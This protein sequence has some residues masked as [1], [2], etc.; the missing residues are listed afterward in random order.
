[1]R[2]G[3]FTPEQA[4]AIVPGICDALQAAH[5]QGIWHR[6]IKPENILL[7][8]DGR[9]KIVDFGI[10]RIVGDPARDFTLTL[11]GAALGSA[12]YMA[13]EQH[14]RTHEVDHRAD[15]YSLGVVF[16]EM[17]TG[18]LPLGRF[19]NPSERAAVHARIDAI[20]LQTLEKERELRQQTATEVKTDIQRAA[21]DG[22]SAPA[23]N[24]VAPSRAESWFSRLPSLVRRSLLAW[25]GGLL[26]LGVGAVLEEERIT[27]A[28]FPLSIG[29][30]AAVLGLLGG[31]W[32]LFEMRRGWLPDTGRGLL[33]ATT[34]LPVL[35]AVA[36]GGTM[37]AVVSATEI[38]YLLGIPLAF[39]C[40]FAV[41]WP[42]R[43]FL[44]PGFQRSR[45][46]V[47][48]SCLL[49][50]G[51]FAG[52][53]FVQGK[54]PFVDATKQTAMLGINTVAGNE[55]V[56]VTSLP[57]FRK[58]AGPL[59]PGY[60]IRPAGLGRIHV[61][62]L[63]PGSA[64]NSRKE[65]M[66]SVVARF[67]QLTDP[68]KGPW[69]VYDHSFIPYYQAD[70]YLLDKF[71]TVVGLFCGLSSLSALLLAWCKPR[72]GLSVA[73][74]VSILGALATFT[75]GWASGQAEQRF[76]P[77]LG[78]LPHFTPEELPREVDFT[79]PEATARTIVLA[80][81]RGQMDILREAVTPELAA[82]LDKKKEWE[83]FLQPNA[84]VRQENLRSNFA[85]P[86]P[87]KAKRQSAGS[88]AYTLVDGKWKMEKPD[89]APVETR[90]RVRDVPRVSKTPEQPVDSPPKEDPV[91]TI[92][93]LNRLAN[94][95]NAE[96]FLARHYKTGMPILFLN[97]VP[98]AR[99]MAP[100]Y[101]EILRIGELPRKDDDEAEVVA[102]FKRPDGKEEYRK[103]ELRLQEN[104]WRLLSDGLPE[105]R[106]WSLVEFKPPQGNAAAIL[107]NHLGKDPFH[108]IAGTDRF[109][110]G[111]KGFEADSARDD[112]EQRHL[113][114]D[115]SLKQ[116]GLNQYLTVLVS[117]PLPTEPWMGG[118]PEVPEIPPANP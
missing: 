46:W 44:H 31:L 57:D 66:E 34:L 60:R 4:L 51:A 72:A 109:L 100:F 65:T 69:Q 99:S 93:L 107:K 90:P 20:V 97:D 110:I 29:A 39:V 49:L 108:P 117:A 50:L 22:G 61:E 42:L 2:A 102:K 24:A 13:P 14:E 19:P 91:A 28:A 73:V 41:A 26:L 94:E 1:M 47:T 56:Q 62:G 48:V 27:G 53:K 18:E 80:A 95:Q 83:R 43:H 55:T 96:A 3:R 30:V 89:Y 7:D 103:F 112:A 71:L 6:D 37:A 15:I 33:L 115:E 78:P 21:R 81:H 101:G 5:A 74:G 12:P 77:D 113:Q 84:A 17:L 67:N 68:T 36:G 59:E 92:R 82:E 35:V 70:A 38:P 64:R 118:E 76:L 105:Y 98:A 11:T 87:D 111:G 16:Y 116:A 104:E 79:S 54:W 45:R 8:Q 85:Y 86:S 63:W 32:S 75:P 9:V 40:T 114:L 10:A 58:A 52:G 88:E 23:E 25:F 106:A